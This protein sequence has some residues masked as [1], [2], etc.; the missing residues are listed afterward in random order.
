MAGVAIELAVGEIIAL[1]E[2]ELTAETAFTTAAISE[3]AASATAEVTM[4]EVAA[5]VSAE[6][7]ANWAADSAIG[8]SGSMAPGIETS[9]IMMED[10]M[11]EAGAETA[12]TYVSEL[13][14]T[15]GEGETSFYTN[16]P[17]P[18][19]TS[20][21]AGAAAPSSDAAILSLGESFTAGEADTSFMSEVSETIELLND[22]VRNW[23]FT[24]GGLDFEELFMGP[25]LE[26]FLREGPALVQVS[27]GITTQ[28]KAIC[29]ALGTIVATVSAGG[30]VAGIST[31]RISAQVV[32]NYAERFMELF[33]YIRSNLGN[34]KELVRRVWKQLQL[35]R[36][37]KDPLRAIA[38][39]VTVLVTV[40]EI[41]REIKKAVEVGKAAVTTTK[42]DLVIRGS[43]AGLRTKTSTK[44][45][46]AVAQ[47]KKT[48]SRTVGRST[49]ANKMKNAAPFK[50]KVD[51]I[52]RS[53]AKQDK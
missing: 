20:T 47:T 33:N 10:L 15:L 34:Y 3:V 26:E 6:V 16:M 40:T 8:M 7:A 53:Q 32:S 51:R 31:G 12:S 22:G 24:L 46:K 49:V 38:G 23:N 17:E 44:K 19:F 18:I 11:A 39:A 42:G 28:Q 50:K 41:Y 37:Q 27:V 43:K 21:P 25:E 52:L 14:V 13:E 36:Q 5:N 48:I 30:V 29:A 4:E 9:E 1:A 35:L 45:V 2:V